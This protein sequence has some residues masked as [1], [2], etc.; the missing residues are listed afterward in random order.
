MPIPPDVEVVG[1]RLAKLR[2][3]IGVD[4]E[5]L[6]D[7]RITM[8]SGDSFVDSQAC[9]AAK[10]CARGPSRAQAY[11][12]ACIDGRI[13]SAVLRHDRPASRR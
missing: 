6:T 9:P 5:G 13:G 8:T 2:L 4:D 10:V 11:L 12:L 3:D 1:R 7:C